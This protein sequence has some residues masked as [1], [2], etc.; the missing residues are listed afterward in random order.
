MF[1]VRMSPILAGR[2]QG[3]GDALRAGDRRRVLD[4]RQLRRR[5]AIANAGASAQHQRSNP[6][7]RG[8]RLLHRIRPSRIVS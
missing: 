5:D 6:G 8:D 1:T 3:H 2:G 4:R 7:A